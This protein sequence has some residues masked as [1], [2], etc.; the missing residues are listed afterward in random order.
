MGKAGSL[1]GVVAF[2]VAVGCGGD[3]PRPAEMAG[4]GG[5]SGGSDATAGGGGAAGA[6]AGVDQGA[7]GGSQADADETGGSVEAG[8]GGAPGSDAGSPP[9][10][11]TTAATCSPAGAEKLFPDAIAEAAWLNVDLTP[12]DGMR[13][14]ADALGRLARED[15]NRP[16]RIRLAPGSYAPTDAGRGEIYIKGLERSAAAPILVQAT[17]PTPNAT[18]L[19]QG[20]TLVA[21]SYLA[22]DG[23]T[24]GPPA[25][26]AFHGSNFCNNDC[27]HDEPKPL[28]AE[29][30]FHIS[31]T[32]I[33]SEKNGLK[34]G[35]LDFTVYGRYAPAHHIVLRR[36]TIQNL[37]A[38]DEPSGVTAAGAGSDGIKFNQAADVWVVG[39][40]IRQTSRHGIDNV[41]VHGGCFLGNF[42]ADVGNGVGIE[43]KGGSIDVT[44][45]GNT[46]VN[47]RRIELGGENTDATFHWSAEP[48]GSPLHYAYE[49]RRIIARNNLVIDAREGGLQFAGCHDCSA[50][51]NT[52]LFRPSFDTGRGGGDAVREVDSVINPEGAGAACTP[53]EGDDVE[54]CWQVG[55]YPVDLVPMP[56]E[57][58]ISR[59]L[60]N[61][62]NTLGN[63]L[64][65]SPTGLW[66]AGLSPYNHPNPTH[67][68]GLAS[69]DHNYY[70]NGAD[71]L[72]DPGDE[73]WLVEGAHS[74]YTGMAA[75]PAVGVDANVSVNV[76]EA[77]AA[78]A[79]RVALRPPAQSPVAGRGS[80]A[81]AGYAAHDGAGKPRPN[82]PA[83]GAL[84]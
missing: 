43:A 67:S 41:A 33:D 10:G 53:R 25:V 37:F 68:Q 32:A 78:A 70:W 15:L 13:G 82:P 38:D 48:P 22:F 28:A 71:P 79:F 55:P 23:V 77:G 72:V 63:N 65:L 66:R 36:V 84:E 62:R 20:F 34:D 4:L 45:D 50:I 81:F 29:A 52:V 76:S 47:V 30:G 64:F 49:G 75:N 9:T 26:G 42:I 40:S 7:A 18:R 14:I 44:Y 31:G 35:H 56:G 54:N 24:I 2:L 59:V 27:Y 8:T 16:V 6:D 51:G 19:G 11:E 73:G 69:V 17:D 80:P 58:G 74:V 61:A 1:V 60:T 12:A 46:F 5:A 3:D 57:N 83:I 21:V 39:S